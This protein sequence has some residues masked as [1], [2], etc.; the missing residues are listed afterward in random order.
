MTPIKPIVTL[1]D[2]NMRDIAFVLFRHRRLFMGA[3]ASLFLIGLAV[4]LFWPPTFGASGSVLLKG[5]MLDRDPSSLETGAAQSLPVSQADLYS[6]VQILSSPALI[7]DAL[8]LLESRDDTA[9]LAWLG[10]TRR[11]QVGAVMESL[12]ASV[13]PSSNVIEVTFLHG[14]PDTALIL[15]EALFESYTHY[16]QR[17]YRPERVD[18]FLASQVA[19]LKERLATKGEQ[20]TAH[21]ERTGLVDADAQ[22][23][24][25]LAL[26]REIE[27]TRMRLEEERARID[28]TTAE[29]TALLS[30]DR[31]SVIAVTPTESGVVLDNRSEVDAWLRQLEGR[32]NA[33]NQTL[34]QLKREAADLNATN[35]TLRREQL[36]L[37]VMQREVGVLEA[38]HD[39]LLKR[40]TEAMIDAEP[41]DQ[42]LNPYIAI[43]SEPRL[44]NGAIFPKPKLVMAVALVAGVLMGLLL[45]ALREVFDPTFSRPVDITSTLG[46]PVLFSLPKGGDLRQAGRP[47]TRAPQPRARAQGR[48][49]ATRATRPTLAGRLAAQARRAAIGTALL[50]LLAGVGWAWA[51]HAKSPEGPG[52]TGGDPGT[53]KAVDPLEPVEPPHA[54]R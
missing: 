53:A 30:S 46:V 50:G 23:G 8:D 28:A 44:F 34:D 4:V 1:A 32:R 22:V 51:S 15:L 14:D 49:A 38:A 6:E 40:Q 33:I 25:N 26:G 18:T 47:K 2:L 20:I 21:M 45:A 42:G 27:S 54:D 11:K 12:T 41:D 52:R 9:T 37:M 36:G 31:A 19:R 39:I 43:L 10:E 3:I 7:A 16:R 24:A 5:R 48:P 29:L 13:V 17:I 35:Q